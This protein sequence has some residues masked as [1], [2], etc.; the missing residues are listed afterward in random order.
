MKRPIVF[1][2]TP[3]A[4]AE[5]LE[6][7]IAHHQVELVITQPD[8][9]RGRGA[10]LMPSPVKSVAMEH[11]IAVEH[12]MDAVRQLSG[13]AQRIG[14]VVAY[15]RIIPADVLDLCPM[16]NIHFSL[17][18]R[19]RGAAP[20]ERAIMA[21]DSH[22]G[23]CIMDVE[24]TLD[25][26]AVHATATTAIEDSD[27]ADS[28]T[29]RLT[30]MGTELLLDVLAREHMM[31]VPQHGEVTYAHKI[32][33]RERIVSWNESSTDIWR[34]VRSLSCYAVLDGKRVGLIEVINEPHVS[35]QPG[36]FGDEVVV[37]A[38][39]GA[40]RLVQVQPEGKKV[41]AAKDWLRGLRSS[42]NLAFDTS[43]PS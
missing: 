20:V 22:T 37:Y 4:S 38:K 26:G 35:G 21:G 34:K 30:R 42:D 16:I 11:G 18:P 23:V 12:S 29:Q 6:E 28:L 9:R 1:F 39:E 43:L 2:G 27:T 31:S 15:G 13:R 19:W 3:H 14:V 40:V 36:T 24:P 41:M 33:P 10:Q 7:L 17:L 5:V 32:E 25:T 8:K